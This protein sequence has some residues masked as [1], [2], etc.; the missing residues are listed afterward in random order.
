MTTY[1][2]GFLDPAS[3]GEWLAQL[4]H[5]ARAG[6]VRLAT[7]ARTHLLALD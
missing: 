1:R 4:P 6:N 7:F 2:S 5:R 3:Q